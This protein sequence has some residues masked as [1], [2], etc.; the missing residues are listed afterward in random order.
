M[1]VEKRPVEILTSPHEPRPWLAV[2]PETHA[3]KRR[4]VGDLLGVERAVSDAGVRGRRVLDNDGDGEIV[5]P[6]LQRCLVR[7]DEVV[8]RPVE[9]H[10]GL[11]LECRELD[12]RG[13]D[14]R[15]VIL[16]TRL[17]EPHQRRAPVSGVADPAI[18]QAE[19]RVPV[20]PQNEARQCCGRPEFA[21]IRVRGCAALEPSVQ[22]GFRLLGNVARGVGH[23]AMG[24]SRGVE[25]CRH[26]RATAAS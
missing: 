5:R 8:R 20:E 9:V 26:P 6:P 10:R 1:V 22:P 14:S 18:G 2:G 13:A 3:V 25:R 15:G 7:D 4:L 12:A 24:V 17:I 19:P 23:A 16:L 11:P 21:C